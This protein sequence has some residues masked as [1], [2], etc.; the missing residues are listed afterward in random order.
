MTDT[1]L[2]RIISVT[3]RS[4]VLAASTVGILGGALFL[5]MH[6][7][8]PVSFHVFKGT[9]SPYASPDKVIRRA[10]EFHSGDQQSH[11]LAIVQLGIMMLLLTPIIRVAFSV[12]GFA[13]ER[14]GIYVVITTIVLA[15]L[16]ASLLLH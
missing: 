12:V 3:L 6:G 1:K 7:T 13:I 14:D 16:T 11:E 9:Q 5:T 15:I 10:L 8:Q 4:G 2:E